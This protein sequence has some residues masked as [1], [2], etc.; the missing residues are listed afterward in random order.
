MPALAAARCVLEMSAAATRLGEIVR[1]GL[2]EGP[3]LAGV[4]G[5]QHAQ[6]GVWGSTV[7]WAARVRATSQHSVHASEKVWQLLEGR[8]H[9][10]A[11]GRIPFDGG[12]LAIYRLDRVD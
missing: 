12:A 1:F 11:V 6:F 2:H 5:F 9:G 7:K 8:V 3:V 4:V 10:E